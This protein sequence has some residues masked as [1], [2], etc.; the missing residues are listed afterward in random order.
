MLNQ[1][2]QNKNEH[3][4][5]IKFI[6]NNLCKYKA[7]VQYLNSTIL[8]QDNCILFIRSLSTKCLVATKKDSFYG[9]VQ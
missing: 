4:I 8:Q 3:I 7:N 9:E 2:L 6:L 1:K 5:F